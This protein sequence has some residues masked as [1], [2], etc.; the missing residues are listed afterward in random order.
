MLTHFARGPLKSEFCRLS[1]KPLGDFCEL[2][3]SMRKTSLVTRSVSLSARG[4]A[5]MPW[6]VRRLL[7]LS[8]ARL[9]FLGAKSWPGLQ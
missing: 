6:A 1:L 2:S 4:I 5:L 9:P 3:V 8:T 7:A